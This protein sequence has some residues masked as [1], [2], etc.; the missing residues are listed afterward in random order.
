MTPDEALSLL[1]KARQLDNKIGDVDILRATAWA[2]ELPEISLKAGQAALSRHYRD[3]SETFNVGHVRPLAKKVMAEWKEQ[4]RIEES[5]SRA[6]SVAERKAVE[7]PGPRL[8]DIA[9]TDRE[10]I[11]FAKKRRAERAAR[12]PEFAAAL[13]QV[14]ATTPPSKPGAL[15][16]SGSMG[17]GRGGGAQGDS[18]ALRGKTMPARL[19]G[20]LGRVADSLKGE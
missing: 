2:E 12:N 3:S 14:E 6:I 1:T 8:A 15:T 11:E 7:G 16:I 9:M 18:D 20:L 19:G 17:S 13:A 5:R 10:K 4:K